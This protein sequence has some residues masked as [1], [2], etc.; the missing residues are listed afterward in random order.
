MT[1]GKAKVE[2]NITLETQ[3]NNQNIKKIMWFL[4]EVLI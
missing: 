2:L 1:I 4:S 3:D